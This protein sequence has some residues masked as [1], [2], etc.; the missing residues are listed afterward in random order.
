MKSFKMEVKRIYGRKGNSLSSPVSGFVKCSLSGL[1]SLLMSPCEGKKIYIPLSKT[2][3]LFF[4]LIRFQFLFAVCKGQRGTLRQYL[5]AK[6]TVT[7]TKRRYFKY[8]LSSC[9][10]E[11]ALCSLI[12]LAPCFASPVFCQCVSC[13]SPVLAAEWR[14]E[15]HFQGFLQLIL[16]RLATL[17][18]VY[19]LRNSSTFCSPS[20]LLPSA[21]LGLLPLLAAANAKADGG[22]RSRGLFRCLLRFAFH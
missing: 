14:P 9:M 11:A 16:K 22:E 2:F 20:C 1:W 18:A 21:C 19:C 17:H 8:V 6:V 5:K 15:L 10:P 7:R 12:S 4:S 13:G 3:P